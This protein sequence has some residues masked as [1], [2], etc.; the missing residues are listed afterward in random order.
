MRTIV[1]SI[2]LGSTGL[3][4]ATGI[5]E[6]TSAAVISA[7]FKTPPGIFEITNSSFGK[8]QGVVS[9]S[10]KGEDKNGD[11]FI[12]VEL[13]PGD[14]FLPSYSEL[15]EFEITS[16]NFG[17]IDSIL[18]PASFLDF[19]LSSTQG[20]FALG[21]RQEISSGKI[22]RFSFAEG[23]PSN[24]N[25]Y[26]YLNS[27]SLSIIYQSNP[28]NASAFSRVFNSSNPIQNVPE[29]FTMIGVVTSVGMRFLLKKEY[30]KRLV[31]IK[32]K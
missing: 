2:I 22:F 15:T 25:K 27:S 28:V 30:S 7:S 3:F 24:A 18:G 21:F 4:L 14:G 20:N 13:R 5:T 19:T 17:I 12:T 23:F 6:P 26:I 11:G 8:S 10:F 29:P 1:K 31:K 9:G 32:G 16:S